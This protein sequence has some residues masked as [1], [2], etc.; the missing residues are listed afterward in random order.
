M[1]SR[2]GKLLVVPLI[3][4]LLYGAA[5]GV[6][7]Y[8]AKQAVDDIVVALADQAD[9]RYRGIDT[10]LRGVV[11][12]RGIEIEPLG[13]EDAFTVDAIK[14]SSDDMM[15]F[16]KGGSW[17]PGQGEPPDSIG[18][19]L[20]GARVPLDSDLA[21]VVSS[22][23]T[24]GPRDACENGL[25]VE[26]VLLQKL[27]FD[28]MLVDV[29]GHYRLDRTAETI[30]MGVLV[31]VKDIQSMEFTGSLS[32]VDVDGLAQGAPQFNLGGFSF[33]LN[34]SPEFG[35]LATKHCASGSTLTLDELS[36]R[37]A[38]RAMQELAMRGV[39]LGAGLQDAVRTFY[40]EWGEIEVVSSPAEPIGI[41]SLMFLPPAQM[42]DALSLRVSLND[43]LITDTRFEWAR[44]TMPSGFSGFFGEEA[45]DDEVASPAPTKRVWIR[46]EF[47]PVAAGSVGRYLD[48]TVRLKP[49]GQPLREGVLKGIADGAAE[50]QQSL[51]G[52]QFTVYVRLS[53]LESAEVLLKREIAAE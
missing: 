34:V 14:V 8:N 21:E 4:L 50:V 31:D 5:K 52:G 33:A 24:G 49:R 26:P 6:M 47:E 51:H 37:F 38:D 17:E 3:L 53:E 29:D 30:E 28:E 2:L 42:A 22:P 46:R 45:V 10:D 25:S 23:G 16:V 40:R 20:M 1:N 41:F 35:R 11:T 18:F 27:G 12:V 44:P 19:H 7:Y 32:D 48:H 39:S 43:E 9:I 15:F 13:F 36:G